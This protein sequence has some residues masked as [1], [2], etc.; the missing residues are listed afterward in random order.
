[1]NAYLTLEFRNGRAK[2]DGNSLSSMAGQLIL[3]QWLEDGAKSIDVLIDGKQ[4]RFEKAQL[5]DIAK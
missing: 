1:M 2:V 4:L 3:R 5:T